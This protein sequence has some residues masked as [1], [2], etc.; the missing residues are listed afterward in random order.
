MTITVTD[1]RAMINILNTQTNELSDAVIQNAIERAN[2]YID[3]LS[4]RSNVSFDLINLAKQNYAAFLAYQTYSDRIVN[5][6]PGSWNSEGIWNPT[7]EVIMREVR[8]K[9]DTLKATSDAS[10][11]LIIAY[12]PTGRLIRPGWITY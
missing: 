10:I 7:G 9:L 4:E 3:A 12:G 8:N 6:I 2:L 11:R 5:E 1:I